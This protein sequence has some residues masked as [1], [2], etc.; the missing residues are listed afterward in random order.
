[1]AVGMA[2]SKSEIDT[3]SGDLARAFQKQFGDVLTLKSF[4]D[5]TDEATLEGLGYTADEVATLKTAIADLFQLGQLWSGQA[6][7]AAAKDFR[8]FVSR[9]WGVGSF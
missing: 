4:L 8:T 1:M 7:L 6:T 9:L 2:V 5:S 3:R